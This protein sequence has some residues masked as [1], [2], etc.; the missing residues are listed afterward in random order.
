MALW[1]S[2]GTVVLHGDPSARWLGT[3]QGDPTVVIIDIYIL[4]FRIF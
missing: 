3:V 4:L 2:T 1:G